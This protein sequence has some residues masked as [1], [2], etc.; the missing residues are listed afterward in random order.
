MRVLSVGS[1][2]PPLSLGGYELAWRSSV[3]QLRS[4]HHQVR[5]LTSDY[6]LPG[7]TPEK[8]DPEVFRELRWYWHEHQ[9][10]RLGLRQRLA[11]ERANRATIRRHLSEFR[12]DVVAWWSMGGMSLSLIEQVRRAGVPSAG[13]I[14]DD[15]L[16]Y[17]P[18][19]DQWTRIF[20]G[21]RRLAAPAAERLAAV[22][23]RVDLGAVGPVLF[24]SA[25]LRERARA[26]GIAAVGARV[27]HRGVEPHL[28]TAAPRPPWR[29]RLLY[30]GRIDR[31]KGID[32]AI[33]ALRDLPAEASLT[34]VGEG[35]PDHLA[36][37]RQLAEGPALA[38]R[39]EFTSSE[40]HLLQGLYAG[41][42]VVLFP[43]RW[44]EPWGLA[45]LEAMAVGAPVVA[46]GR[47]GSAEYLSDHQNCLIFDPDEGP[48]ALAA[49]VREMGS[50]PALRAQLREGGFETSGRLD[51]ADYDE[52][53]EQLLD[54]AIR[55]GI[56]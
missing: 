10:P 26:A 52:A 42:D 23:A 21:R 27:G 13:V 28:F 30:V 15:W 6:G 56:R 22:P 48:G 5:V 1:M 35:D 53:I 40:R 24:A 54:E 36:E 7:G 46:S 18:A 17:A 55:G 16:L 38:G 39:V 8:P 12:P 9:W 51:V 45:P 25:T 49:A 11:L 41:A 32:L 14:C 4:K 47:G 43:V 20:R 44:E 33:E 29:W 2:Y 31:R 50:D 3:A 19:V 37:L 34:V